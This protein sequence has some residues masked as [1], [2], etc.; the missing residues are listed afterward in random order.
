MYDFAAAR[1]HMVEGQIRTADVTE[2]ALVDALRAVERE[3]FA[4][5]SKRTLVYGDI[6]IQLGEG[7]WLMRPRDFAKLAQA[8]E[9]SSDD[10]VLDIACGR[11]Y[12][13]AVFARLAETVVGLESDAALAAKASDALAA[14]GADNAAIV[15]GSLQAGAPGQGPFDVVFVN[16]AVSAPPQTWFDLLAE[17]GRLGVVV[18][19]G[20]V[21]HATVFTR[22]G[23]VIGD[24]IV[25]DSAAPMLPGFEQPAAFTF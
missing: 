11:G 18:K 23:G 10:V 16:G 1:R 24:R 13:T 25:F 17:G 6:D 7:R 20:P 8:L 12:S 19:K 21:G 3:Q 22:A 4:P 5:K 14:A 15:E 9:I 2:P